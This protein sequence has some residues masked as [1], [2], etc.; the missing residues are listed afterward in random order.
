MQCSGQVSALGT[1]EKN[2][3][4]LKGRMIKSTLY[5]WLWFQLYPEKYNCDH[6]NST[7]PA[8]KV[9][10]SINGL[11]NS[12]SLEYSKVQHLFEI[13]VGLFSVGV[14]LFFVTVGLRKSPPPTKKSPTLTE[15]SPTLTVKS[16]TYKKS[17][18]N[19]K[20]SPPPTKKSPTLTEK[21]LLIKSPPL[22]KKKSS[23]NEKKSYS[24]RK[25]SYSNDI[26]CMFSHRFYKTWKSSENQVLI[27]FEGSQ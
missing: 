20:K 11:E 24:D 1:S 15:K 2:W 3:V 14:G 19:Q 13:T 10:C 17:S 27:G 16:P 9:H 6:S 21:A 4:A 7:P 5:S 8:S 18:S 23:S 26:F 12:S 22:T 25:K